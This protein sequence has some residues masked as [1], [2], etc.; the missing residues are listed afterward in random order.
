MG[1]REVG[2]LANMLAAHM[3]IENPVHNAR[4]KQFWQ[5]PHMVSKNGQKAVDMFDDMAAGKI[6]FIWIMGT[7]PVVSMPNRLKIEAALKRCDMVVVSDIVAHTD[8]L[9]L[10]NIALPASG[11]SEKDGTVTNSERCISRQ[12]GLMPLP[13]QS[14][15]DW[16]IIRDLALKL[17]HKSQFNY[18]HAYE[19]FDEHARLSGFE[20]AGQRDFDISGLAGLDQQGFDTLTPIQWPVNQTH[21]EGKKRLFEEGRYFTE[22]GKANFVV[23]HALL[24]QQVV[25]N[26]FPFVLNTGRMRDQWHTMTR[27][28]KAQALVEHTQQA[29]VYMHPDDAK[30]LDLNNNELIALTSRHNTHEAVVAPIHISD[31]LTSGQLFAPIHWSKTNTSHGGLTSLFTSAND[32]ISGQPELKHAAVAIQ[33]IRP[34]V[35]IAL[36]IK[37][38]CIDEHTQLAEYQVRINLGEF[39]LYHLAEL[40]E[41]SELTAPRTSQ[42]SAIPTS[43][44]KSNANQASQNKAL[45]FAEKMIGVLTNAEENSLA[46]PIT[47]LSNSQ[48]GKH[49]KSQLGFQDHAL[50]AYFVETDQ[51]HSQALINSEFIREC[52]LQ[53]PLDSAQKQHLLSAT[54]PS[55]YQQ[56][57]LICS[58]FKVR[59]LTIEKAI[60][61]GI[62][63]VD[64]L[65]EKLKCGT[66][67]GSCKSELASFIQASPT[68]SAIQIPI[69]VCLSPTQL[70]QHTAMEA[71]K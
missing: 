70:T 35:A 32:P 68:L 46:K 39:W 16:Q 44:T 14:K 1:G 71:V 36:A 27:T 31:D 33:K 19:I 37:K 56:G 63:T 11:W 42:M 18:S 60:E 23:V 64:A 62:N 22:N 54:S 53:N 55:E 48:H 38:S 29:F 10:A 2:G 9:A 41:L 50:V 30:A 13:G 4:V 58:C 34:K 61:Q 17:G 45:A 5:A 26:E 40:A 15:H 3:D 25:S 51:A 21:P 66:N 65:G 69:K 7:N 59:K 12:R 20:N 28:G 49:V 47:W 6:K 57:R 8:T 43:M 24:P 52:F 67:C